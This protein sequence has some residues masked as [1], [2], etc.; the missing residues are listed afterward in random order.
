LV[1]HRRPAAWRCPGRRDLAH[2]ARAGRDS[3]RH[4]PEVTPATNARGRCAERGGPSHWRGLTQVTGSSA[5]AAGRVTL[6]DASTS[7]DSAPADAA[8]VFAI[9]PGT[10]PGSETW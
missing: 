1:L 5:M 3:G 7:H 4:R 9:W 6:M 10:A 2:P 8:G